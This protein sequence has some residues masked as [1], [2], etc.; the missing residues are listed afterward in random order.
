[1]DEVCL[2]CNTVVFTERGGNAKMHIFDNMV[3]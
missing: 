1:M 2:Y 3:L